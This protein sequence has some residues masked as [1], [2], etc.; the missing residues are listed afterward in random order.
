MTVRAV[1]PG[2]FRIGDPETEWPSITLIGGW[3]PTSRLAH[4]PLLD[5]CPYTGATDVEE[6][7]LG[8]RG[9]LWG[10]TAVTAPP[11]G[12]RGH[13]PYGFGIVELSDGLRV[14]GRI[15]ESDPSL[16][17]F[18]Q[19]MRLVAEALYTDDDTGDTVITWAFA[20]G[21]SD[22]DGVAEGPAA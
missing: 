16:L 22:R 5:T 12:Y 14:L 1:E 8:T 11:P 6:R 21:A 18:G 2:L 20:P 4:F 9:T 13:V 10:W 19:P 3:S 7:D 17:S 15:T